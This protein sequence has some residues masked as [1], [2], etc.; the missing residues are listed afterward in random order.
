MRDRPDRA[1]VSALVEGAHA[2]SEQRNAGQLDEFKAIE[3]EYLPASAGPAAGSESRS[4]SVCTSTPSTGNVGAE[5]ATGVSDAAVRSTSSAT[6]A[7]CC[8]PPTAGPTAS[9]TS[10]STSAT[11]SRTASSASRS[12]R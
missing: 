2:A 6:A 4:I 5:S 11:W 8:S 1:T 9:A 10:T 12:P 3:D 7:R